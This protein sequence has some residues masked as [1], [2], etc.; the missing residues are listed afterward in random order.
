MKWGP[1]FLSG[2][3]RQVVRVAVSPFVQALFGGMKVG[4][5]GFAFSAGGGVDLRVMPHVAVRPQIDYIGLRLHGGTGN[6]MR[7]SASLVFRF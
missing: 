2:I 6:T 3:G 4:D 7:A 1:P 5:T